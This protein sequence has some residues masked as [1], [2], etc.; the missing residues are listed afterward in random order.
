MEIIENILSKTG[1]G[2]RKTHI[3][4]AANLSSSQ[5]RRYLT[6][7]MDAK[8]LLYEPEDRLF[9]MT[10]KGSNLLQ[11]IHEI[12]LAK[13]NLHRSKEKLRSLI[14]IRTLADIDSE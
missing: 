12:S 2:C 7:L 1:N 13:E 3:M 10:P 9:M 6:L 8:C 11:A 5:M 14:D 4:Y